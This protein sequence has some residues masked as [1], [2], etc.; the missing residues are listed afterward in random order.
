MA[1]PS[2]GE[3][4]L[5]QIWQEIGGNQDYT[6]DD[7]DEENISLISLSTG[8]YATTNISNP[9]DRRPDEAAPHGMEEF[10]YYDHD[11]AFTY[12]GNAGNGGG[13]VD[14]FTLTMTQAGAGADVQVSGVK[15]HTLNNS[16]GNTEVFIHSQA[17]GTNPPQIEISVST[18]GDPGSD[19]TGN[20]A[21]GFGTPSVGSPVVLSASG[22]YY[23]RV[24]ATENE[25]GAKTTFT[26]A[27]YRIKNNS[28][29]D[30]VAVTLV[31]S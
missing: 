16:S 13:S 18:S 14:D 2:S 29:I 23:V 5:K 19:G 27:N 17:G 22:R 20:S 3:L 10:Y 25:S 9:S 1:V 24:K 8:I 31:V 11:G 4:S 26:G 12:W 6:D 7:L 15:T 30:I 21:S 28:V